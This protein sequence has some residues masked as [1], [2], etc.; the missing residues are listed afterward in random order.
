MMLRR[1]FLNS[2]LALAGLAPRASVG[3]TV[4]LPRT[5]LLQTSPVAGFQYHQGEAVWASLREGLALD[6]VREPANVHDD[7]AVRVEWTG[8]KLGYLPRVENHAVAQMLDRGERLDARIAGVRESRDP[9]E[10]AR[11]EVSLA[12]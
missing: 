9:W 7:K 8:H 2:L 5:V 4:G 6:L 10:R 12:I 11:I 3:R 1:T